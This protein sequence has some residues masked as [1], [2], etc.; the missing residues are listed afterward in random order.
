VIKCNQGNWGI[1]S[2]SKLQYQTKT[3]RFVP[4]L[5][6]FLGELKKP[7]CRLIFIFCFGFQ[8]AIFNPLGV[9]IAI[10]N[11]QQAKKRNGPCTMSSGALFG[12]GRP[13]AVK[14]TVRR[15]DVEG[16]RIKSFA[17]PLGHLFMIR[18]RGVAKRL[19]KILVPPDTAN[20][21]RR[22]RPPA[23]G[24]NWISHFGLA[25][26]HLHEALTA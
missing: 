2:K 25:R 20:I 15:A 22:A 3:I 10:R 19:Q 8:K 13:P 17:S 1:K 18:V 14:V 9:K 4:I 5:M 6:C 23:G 12:W 24:Y 21:L 7:C 11:E 16:F 26:K